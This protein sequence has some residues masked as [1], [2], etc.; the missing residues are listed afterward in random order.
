MVTKLYIKRFGRG[1][2]L[3]LFNVIC[4]CSE[5]CTSYS[6]VLT[7]SKTEFLIGKVDILFFL[8]KKTKLRTELHLLGGSAGRT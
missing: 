5:K 4:D 8:K 7:T 1:V 3:G 6:Q 2:W